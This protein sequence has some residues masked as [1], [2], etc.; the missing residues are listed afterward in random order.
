MR[1]SSNLSF[2]SKRIGLHKRINTDAHFGLHFLC[3]NRVRGPHLSIVLNAVDI[4]SRALRNIKPS[5]GIQCSYIFSKAKAINN[6]AE[7]LK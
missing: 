4:G 3:L 2:L 6:I 7:T 5:Q 1:D